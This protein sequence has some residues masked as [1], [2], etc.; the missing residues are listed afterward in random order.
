MYRK[1]IQPTPHGSIVVL[2]N[3]YE[4]G[5]KIAR[6]LLSKPTEPATVK[7]EKLFPGV[8]E[9]SCSTIDIIA[10]DICDFLDGKPIDFSLDIVDLGSCGQFQQKVLRAE[11]AIPRGRVSSYKAIA[12]HLGSPGRARAAGN[13]LAT[14]PF[15]IIVPCHRAIRSDGSLGGYQGGLEMKRDLL[16]NEGIRFTNSGCVDCLDFYYD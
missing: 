16:E 7:A 6:I 3:E 14:N 12:R 2:W 15:P 9:F 8:H 5:E 4:T 11:H 13:A 1:I 10:S